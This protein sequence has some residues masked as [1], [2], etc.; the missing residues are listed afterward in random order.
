MNMRTYLPFVGYYILIHSFVLNEWWNSL[1]SIRDG[2]KF[3]GFPLENPDNIQTTHFYSLQKSWI[4][5]FGPDLKT[6]S[7]SGIFNVGKPFVMCHLF[8]SFYESFSWM[9]HFRTCSK[10]SRWPDLTKNI[11]IWKNLNGLNFELILGV[12]FHYYFN[13]CNST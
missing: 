2:Y 13:P 3:G 1:L 5:R 8:E 11:F 9:H 10:K 6:F 7:P 4:Y 12:H